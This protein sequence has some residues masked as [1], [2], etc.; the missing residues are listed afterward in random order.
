MAEINLK[1]YQ[2]Y[3]FLSLF[4][5]I[6]LF[7]ADSTAQTKLKRISVTERSDGLGYVVRYH[8]T[9]EVDS[10]KVSQPHLNS[11]QMV[12]FQSDLDTTN[13]QRPSDNN[14]I[15]EIRIRPID[16]AV[17]FKIIIQENL[18]L[19]AKAYRD[20][21]QKDV[22]LSLRYTSLDKLKNVV[23]SRNSL[24]DNPEKS[25]SKGKNYESENIDSR[26]VN[27]QSNNISNGEKKGISLI[28]SLD[29]LMPDDPMELYA[30][31]FLND[32]I[33]TTYSYAIRPLGSQKNQT[34]PQS[35]PWNGHPFFHLKSDKV[36]F[37]DWFIYT[38]QV[39]RSYNTEIPMG[40]N[41][42][43]LWQGRGENY[44]LSA[45]V[46]ARFGPLSV[47]FR[48]VF[49]SVENKE[50]RL[51]PFPRFDGL[52]EYAMSLMNIDMPQRFGQDSLQKFYLGDSFI[53][54]DYKGWA[55]GISNQRIWTGPSIYNPLMLGYNAPGFLH[56]FAGTQKPFEFRYGSLETRWF[57]GS[58]EE[59][60]FFDQN[61]SNNRRLVTGFTFN[62]SPDFIRGLHVGL[63]RVAFSYYPA[64]GLSAS[65]FLM[66][67]RLPQSKNVTNPKKAF[68]S[69]MSVFAR[70]EFPKAGFEVY[71]EW[72]RNDNRRE[73]R[74][75]LLEPEFNRGYILG[76]LKT[77][78]LTPNRKLL[79]STEFTNVE[80]SSV[81]SQQR[82]FNTWYEHEVIRQGFTHQ[83]Q[84][85]GTAVGPGSSTQVMKLSYYEKRGMLGVSLQRVAMY[86]DRFHRYRDTYRNL[87]RFP[88]F[89]FMVDRHAVQM[90]YGFHGL[91]FFP[92]GFELQLDYHIGK[93]ENRYNL[94]QRD[95]TNNLFKVTM[96]Y[97]IWKQL[98]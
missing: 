68:H 3:F 92:Y 20:V 51:S 94:Y 11:V 62:Y 47:V 42:G 71:A 4:C 16:E 77:I 45:G 13:F 83:G 31:A 17:G 59:S 34:L 12:L 21:N 43:A 24:F 23:S 84:V 53:Q 46:G 25:Q 8:L 79:L 61:P 1:E 86:N 41:D 52:S 30:R 88:E 29:R 14:V 64:N 49:T 73:I 76:F 95:L 18:L 33:G 27:S 39:F 97:N 96:R 38:P 6:N 69:M 58:L 60:G 55:A 90:N 56:A 70:W 87:Y 48:P 72:G 5:A 7:A 22:L 40:Y 74:D 67:F 54:L 57:W 19:L 10:F 44:N 26:A 2:K 37:A 85:L 75:L 78:D 81:T 32:T 36:T 65:D 89:W 9:E 15:Q 63:T 28:Q 80:N 35:H 82:D 98:Q 50:F 93:F 91:I 66:A